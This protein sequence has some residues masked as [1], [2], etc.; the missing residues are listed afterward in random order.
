MQEA[1]RLANACKTLKEK[2]VVW[3]MLDTGLRVFEFCN[4][5]KNNI[6][7][8]LHR[9]RVLG[10]GREGGKRRVVP[11]TERLRALLE[12]YFALQD[13][14][15]DVRLG[16]RTAEKIVK[17]VANRAGIARP[18]MPHVLRHTFAVLSLQKGLS[19]PSLQKILGH[20][21]LETTAI[22]LNISNDEAVRE[23]VDK[24]I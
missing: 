21:R 2:L 10:K 3:T 6:E 18:C 7:W 15:G 8:Q 14:I 23:F 13:E 17:K 4:L 1:D 12:S 24:R 22:Y 20:A 19:L 16:K 5:S 11:M 9:I